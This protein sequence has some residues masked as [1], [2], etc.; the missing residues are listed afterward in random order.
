MR[1]YCRGPFEPIQ[2]PNQDSVFDSLL[3]CSDE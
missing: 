3:I 1:V 2:I